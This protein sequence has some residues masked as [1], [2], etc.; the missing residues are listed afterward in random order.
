MFLIFWWQFIFSENISVSEY[1]W[2]F[3]WV[4]VFYLLLE[5]RNDNKW[6]NELK[7]WYIY[8][9]ISII[10][11]SWLWLLQKIIVIS[12]FDVLTYVFYSGIFWSLASLIFKWKDNIREVLSAI[13][14]KHVLFLIISALSFGIWL[15]SHLSSIYLGWDIAIVYKIISYSLFF[16]IIFSIIYYK[17]EITL[18]K[19]I[20]F[21]LTVISIFLFV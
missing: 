1:L 12:D 10:L 2:V 20:A 19:I 7:R 15:Y 21:I 8:L 14:K 16:P 13:D 9:W 5:K 17:E 6:K 11:S 3:M 4:I 18:K